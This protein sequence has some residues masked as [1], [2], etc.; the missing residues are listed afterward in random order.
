MKYYDI[1]DVVKINCAR[2]LCAKFFFVDL[3]DIRP[4]GA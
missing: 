1:P 3:K 2:E 4:L